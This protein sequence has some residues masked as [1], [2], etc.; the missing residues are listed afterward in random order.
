VIP[1]Y[2]PYNTKLDELKDQIKQLQGLVPPPRVTTAVE[3]TNEDVDPNA[4]SGAAVGL[5]A[6]SEAGT[7]GGIS[8]DVAA[9]GIV[10]GTS[11][12]GSLM[13]NAAD[14][15][16]LERKLMYDA[17]NTEYQNKARAIQATGEGERQAFSR[18]MQNIRGVI[19]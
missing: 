6:G 11:L 9:G 10:A 8:G 4:G 5:G 14:R 15:K 7:P 3:D 17:I 1:S 19:R 13:K 2:N 18:I 12:F 16:A